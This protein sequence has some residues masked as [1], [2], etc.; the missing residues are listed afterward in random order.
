MRITAVDG[1]AS[2][3]ELGA[4]AV[5]EAGLQARV[6][7]MQGYIP[8][9]ALPERSFDAIVSK[10]LLHHLPDPSALWSEARRLGRPGAILYVMDLIRPE[11]QQDAH[12][13]V[14]RV[15]SNEHPILKQDFFNS[16]CAAFT[17]QE[18]Q[19]QLHHARLALQVERIGDRH[20][21][22]RGRLP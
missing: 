2:M 20:M 9:L 7:P 15:A 1:S 18:V 6:T 14:E 22:I 5:R 12:D 11:T 21:L 17:M 4:Q 13:I 8:G 16:L 3:I 10:D 19:S